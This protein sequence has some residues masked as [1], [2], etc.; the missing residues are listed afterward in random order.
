M[1][2]NKTITTRK[3][4]FVTGYVALAVVLADYL[5]YVKDMPRELTVP[6]MSGLINALSNILKHHFGY[7]I[8]NSDSK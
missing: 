2:L 8:F 1:A 7:N 3:A 6:V 4:G 5:P